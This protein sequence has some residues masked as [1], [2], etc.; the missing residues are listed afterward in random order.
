MNN[1]KGDLQ[2]RGGGTPITADCSSLIGSDLFQ[3]IFVVFW[4][5][6]EIALNWN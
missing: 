5:L 2:K 1:T 4:F 3:D 6:Q